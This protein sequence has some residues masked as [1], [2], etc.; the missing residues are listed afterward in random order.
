MIRSTPGVVDVSEVRLRWHGHRL[1]AEASITVDTKS[2]LV[3][4]HHLSHLVEHDLL[5][6]VRRLTAATIHAE[7][8]APDADSAHALVSHHG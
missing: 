6:G 2:S 4:A 8:L 5:H 3:E 7:P 1:L